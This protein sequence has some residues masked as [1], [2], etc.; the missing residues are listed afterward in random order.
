MSGS[1][2]PAKDNTILPFSGVKAA[3]LKLQE[4]D[5][6]PKEQYISHAGIARRRFMCEWAYRWDAAAYLL[7][8]A[9]PVFS[10]DGTFLHIHRVLPEIYK[11][12]IITLPVK[13][14]KHDVKDDWGNVLAT[15]GV[16][17]RES[18][19]PWL[20]ATNITS[21][22][23]IGRQG[24]TIFPGQ[25][26]VSSFTKAEIEV[27][28]VVRHY[29]LLE[30]RELL[31]HNFTR[32]INNKYYPDEFY[33]GRFCSFH[34]QP[35]TMMMEVPRGGMVWAPGT[36][37]GLAGKQ[38]TSTIHRQKQNLDIQ[39]L[40]YGVPGI[41]SALNDQMGTLNDRTWEMHPPGHVRKFGPQTL[42]YMG[43]RVKTYRQI[44]GTWANDISLLFSFFR[45]GH[46]SEYA[47]P[48]GGEYR[49]CPLSSFDDAARESK[50]HMNK[51]IYPETNF[52]NLF[53]L[54]NATPPS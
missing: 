39:V 31:E 41:P 37:H 32:R 23:G 43:Y 4:L 25:R 46:N 26:S 49:W 28:Y 30:D 20:W 2:T 51:M 24:I 12:S 35:N 36:P 9:E 7:G 19:R 42:I 5:G 14:L 21:M 45:E 27:E 16:E 50:Q 52:N 1:F 53:Q 18:Q 29:R 48:T 34:P 40:W 22:K 54:P 38:A 44:T 8:W 47:F 11:P 10:P 17:T 6:S 13:H 3:Q 15:G 33:A